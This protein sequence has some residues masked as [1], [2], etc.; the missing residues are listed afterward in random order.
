MVLCLVFDFGADV[1]QWADCDSC[2]FDLAG[3]RRH[4]FAEVASADAIADVIVNF[5][6]GD[7][8]QVR[9]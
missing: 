5:R 1:V 9:D 7:T 2:V 8:P 4:V 3:M 6:Q